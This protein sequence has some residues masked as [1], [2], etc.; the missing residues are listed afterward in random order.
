M[1]FFNKKSLTEKVSEV[2]SSLKRNKRKREEI[3][4]EQDALAF[5]SP[6]KQ[7]RKSDDSDQSVLMR[8]LDFFTQ[9]L[10]DFR[11]DTRRLKEETDKLHKLADRT[12]KV[13]DKFENKA[14]SNCENLL[15]ERQIFDLFLENQRKEGL[16][17]S[18]SGNK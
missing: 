12:M 10:P 3:E 2:A 15:K 9:F 7:Q 8:V 1:G 17:V 5:A 6:R 11:R 13:L 14:A 18:R 16:F 4:G